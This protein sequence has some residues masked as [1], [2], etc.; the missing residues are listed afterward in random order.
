MLSY[1]R[2]QLSIVSFSYAQDNA[3]SERLYCGI[4]LCFDHWRGGSIFK[5]NFLSDLLFTCYIEAH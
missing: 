2:Q 1:L 5:I 4:L 3:Y